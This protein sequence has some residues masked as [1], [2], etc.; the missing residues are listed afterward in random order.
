MYHPCQTNLFAG[1]FSNSGQV[2]IDAEYNETM[3]SSL[4]KNRPNNWFVNQYT[5]N[6]INKDQSDSN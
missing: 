4:L 6:Y 2:V 5:N 3:V 1:M